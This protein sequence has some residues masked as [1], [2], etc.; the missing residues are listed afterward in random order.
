MDRFSKGQHIKRIERLRERNRAWAGPLMF[1]LLQKGRGMVS[2]TKAEQM[3]FVRRYQMRAY[4]RRH[5]GA[6]YTKEPAFNVINHELGIKRFA[7][8]D[9]ITGRLTFQRAGFN[10]NT[11]NFE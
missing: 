8:R 6:R 3:G 9:N 10:P 2:V 4:R 1:V 5:R 7:W 11:G